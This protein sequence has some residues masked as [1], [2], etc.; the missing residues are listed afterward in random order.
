MSSK[1]ISPHESDWMVGIKKVDNGYILQTCIKNDDKTENLKELLFETKGEDPTSELHV[2]KDLMYELIDIFAIDNSKHDE[3][4]LKIKVERNEELDDLKIK[5]E[6]SDN[7]IFN[8]MQSGV[9]SGGQNNNISLWK[10][11]K[12]GLLKSNQ[13]GD[14]TL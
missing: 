5:H 7:D 12:G 13:K 6:I 14:F 11:S 10:N 2:F 9:I 4:N 3:Y 8:P 1:F